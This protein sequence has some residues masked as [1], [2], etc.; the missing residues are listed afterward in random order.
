[1]SPAEYARVRAGQM[2]LA[3]GDATF[4]RATRHNDT[5]RIGPTYTPIRVVGEWHQL[6]WVE[7]WRGDNEPG[8]CLALTAAGREAI[9]ERRA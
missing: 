5:L 8:S 6:G 2:H 1:M 3:F 9:H 4:L 7:T